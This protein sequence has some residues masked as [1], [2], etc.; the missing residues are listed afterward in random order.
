MI[1]ISGYTLW[2]DIKDKDQNVRFSA[3]EALSSVLGSEAVEAI[4]ALIEGLNSDNEYSRQSAREA[5]QKINTHEAQKALKE[6]RRNPVYPE[7]QSYP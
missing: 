3:A 6:H 5:L 7:N 1:E 2:I 4:P